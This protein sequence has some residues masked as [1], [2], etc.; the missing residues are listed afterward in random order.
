[1]FDFLITLTIPYTNAPNVLQ[2]LIFLYP[3]KMMAMTGS[4]LLTVG[5]AIER[6]TAVH[7]P[8]SYM[9]AMGNVNALKKRVASY[10]IPVA[11]ICPRQGHLLK[12]GWFPRSRRSH[13]SGR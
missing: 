13:R 7:Y 4:I 8:I 5:I 2:T 12:T 9:Q 3:F 10:I 1:M 11:I 6:Y